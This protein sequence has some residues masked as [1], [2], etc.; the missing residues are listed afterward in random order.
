MAHEAVAGGGGMD[1]AGDAI[2]IAERFVGKGGADF[3]QSR[4]AGCRDERAGEGLEEAA[5]QIEREGFFEREAEIGN[6]AFGVDAPGFA[7]VVFDALF[8]REAG[9]RQ[10]QKIAADGFYADREFGHEPFDGEAGGRLAKE[11]DQPPVA[12]YG[13]LGVCGWLLPG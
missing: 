6:A 4:L 13:G 7:A 2:E 11:A 5:T 8:E 9:F 3:S 10:V 12:D 1:R